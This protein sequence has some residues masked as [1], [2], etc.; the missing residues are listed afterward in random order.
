MQVTNKKPYI[1][2]L[3][4]NG[5]GGDKKTTGVSAQAARNLSSSSAATRSS[6]FS[7][8]Q[9][10]RTSWTS[11]QHINRDTNKYDYQGARAQMN[12]TARA[13]AYKPLRSS[14]S[15]GVH[16][17]GGSA[18][19]VNFEYGNKAYMT[20]NILGQVAGNTFGFL[21]QVGVIDKIKGSSIGEKIGNI[22]GGGSDNNSTN[23][24][25][26]SSSGAASAISNMASCGDSASLR[27]A[28]ATANGQLSS[29]QAQSGTLKAAGEQAEKNLESLKSAVDTAKSDVKDRTQDLKT[30]KD[31][32]DICTKDRDNK[33]IALKN[34]N[35]EYGEAK[36]VHREKTEAHNQAKAHT[37]EC[38]A[39]V[40]SA[41]SAFDGAKAAYASAPEQIPDGNGGMK[42]N[43]E[44]AQLKAKMEAA[45]QKL[46]DA[47]I[48]LSR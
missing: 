12:G 26:V 2:G 23:I 3:G 31:S 33:Q 1:A 25:N 18:N 8:S 30:A 16:F 38:Q 45:E 14:Q 13:S 7:F 35:G 48:W 11:G 47:K 37:S 24:G 15:T 44:K 32:V 40:D 39:N 29:L 43:P 10:N 5:F 28:I 36:Q 9:S 4:G 21:N 22:F 20:G 41:Q 46:N 19:N 27:A 6:V 42:A 34:A 17:S